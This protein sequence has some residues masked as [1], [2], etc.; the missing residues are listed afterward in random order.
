MKKNLHYYLDLDYTIRLKENE[1]GT[2]FAEI[3]ELVGC[4]SEG[5]TKEEAVS[6]IEDAK[7]VWLE[8]ALEKKIKI[9]EPVSDTFSGK[10]NIR[11]PKYLHRK[12]TYRA[13]EEGVS[14]NTFIS[15]SLSATLK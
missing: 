10:L 13:K 3:E 5:D 2:F 14:L 12:L 6:M 1:D 9:P 8:L 11:L 4:I 7:K 15:T